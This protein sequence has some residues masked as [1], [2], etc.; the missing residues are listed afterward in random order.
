[1]NHQLCGHMLYKVLHHQNKG[2]E[3]FFLAKKRI[4]DE[5]PREDA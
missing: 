5:K 1:M 2:I 3:K 4:T